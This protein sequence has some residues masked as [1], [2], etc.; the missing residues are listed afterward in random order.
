MTADKHASLQIKSCAYM[1][2]NIA[3]Y[4]TITADRHFEFYYI[5]T[6]LLHYSIFNS[7]YAPKEEIFWTVY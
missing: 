2:D 1:L 5:Y 6:Y 4:D 7:I 3:N